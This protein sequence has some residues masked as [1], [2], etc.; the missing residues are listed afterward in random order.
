MAALWANLHASFAGW[1]AI[2]TLL[3][4][5]ATCECD[6]P[7]IWRYGRLTL[8]SIVATLVNPYGWKLH[9]HIAAYV[10]SGWILDHVQEFQSPRI[11]TENM[12]V[13]AALLI[14]ALFLCS[15]A[16]PA[17]TFEKLLVIFWGFA[18]LR[19]AR[20]VPWF[21]VVSAPMIASAC[22]DWWQNRA[23]QAPARSAV[24]IFWDAGNELGRCCSF[25]WWCPALGAA[26]LFLALPRQGLSDF[27]GA[28]FPVEAVSRNA[29]LLSGSRVLTTDQWADYLIYKL[30]PKCRV[31]FDGRSDFYGPEVGED[32]RALLDADRRWREIV[33]RNDFS[34]ALLPLDWPLGQLLEREPGW[35]LAARDEQSVL[36]VRES[37]P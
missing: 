26:A 20:H 17:R 12:L 33:A 9:A 31:F 2:L 19:S 16:G 5:A 11:R 28:R 37:A 13:F 21:A 18:A 4:I 35:R 36:L 29:T 30:H 10:N 23:L 8:L 24:R 7:A 1:L 22:S 3:V 27:P 6:L 32:Y 15:R 34:A 14:T 25:S